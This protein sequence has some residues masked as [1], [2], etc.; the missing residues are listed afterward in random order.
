MVVVAAV[1]YSHE[2]EEQPNY[3][4]GGQMTRFSEFYQW[5]G[6]L[7]ESGQQLRIVALSG[8]SH[9]IVTRQRKINLVRN[10]TDY[11]QLR[12]KSSLIYSEAECLIPEVH[13]KSQFFAIFN[14]KK[15][16]KCAHF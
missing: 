12:D 1:I 4:G 7:V 5:V 16:V 9:S 15:T 2:D 13:F 14:A 6:W 8:G 11:D 10:T 3:G